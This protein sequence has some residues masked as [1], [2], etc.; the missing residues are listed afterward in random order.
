MS[1]AS[2]TPTTLLPAILSVLEEDIV[3]GRLLP[4]E[5]LIEEDLVER[6][7]STRHVI[8]QALTDLERAGL[9][10]RIPNRGAQVKA[11]TAEEVQ[12]LYALREML[13]VQA[14]QLIPL[15][16]QADLLAALAA[17]QDQHDEAVA[18]GDARAVFRADIAFHRALYALCGNIFLTE[19]IDAL[20]QRAQVI[21]Y[22]TLRSRTSMEQARDQHHGM[23][24]AL[25]QADRSALVSLCLAH[26]QPARSAYLRQ[27][28]D[29]LR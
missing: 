11:Y 24:Q 27:H 2:R 1:E 5:R 8:R 26:F 25:R 7:A 9:I 14:A 28:H 13:E 12:Q 6:F 16:V 4:R 20:G 18:Q 3:F 29:M 21:R 15:P 19:T 22:A 10:D 23:L 17:L